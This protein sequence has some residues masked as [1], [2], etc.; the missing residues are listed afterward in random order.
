MR[1]F[2]LAPTGERYGPAEIATLNEW[3]AA[4]RLFPN[5]QLME[6]MGGSVVIASTV[7]G[8]TFGQAVPPAP[9][10]GPMQPLAPGTY[11][12]QVPPAPSNYPR[13]Y[14]PQT[15]LPTDNGLKDMLFAF[16]ICIGAPL[17]A[18][19]TWYGIFGAVAGVQ[20]AWKAYQKGQK[21]AILALVLNVLAIFVGIYMRFVLRYQVLSSRY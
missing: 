6:E 10:A 16:G 14:T 8:I 17:L 7:P 3:A 19:I 20:L 2:V 13:G 12:P 9:A 4:N 1:Y 18:F 5:S 11:A 15:G 21:L